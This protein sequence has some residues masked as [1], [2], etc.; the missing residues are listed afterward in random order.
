MILFPIIL[1]AW[2]GKTTLIELLPCILLIEVAL[3]LYG[4]LDILPVFFSSEKE[5]KEK[6]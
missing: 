5:K 4:I 6:S 2:K 1:Y 3:L